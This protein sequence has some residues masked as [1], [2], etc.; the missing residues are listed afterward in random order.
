MEYLSCV[1][2]LTVARLPAATAASHDSTQRATRNNMQQQPPPPTH[3]C[4][5][6]HPLP[7]QAG[8]LAFPAARPYAMPPRKAPAAKAKAARASPKAAA[9][10]PKAA[11]TVQHPPANLELITEAQRYMDAIDGVGVKTT[12]GPAPPL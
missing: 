9:E 4:S 7:L 10:S 5:V 8:S 6:A 2:P 12:R 11:V 3:S 1:A